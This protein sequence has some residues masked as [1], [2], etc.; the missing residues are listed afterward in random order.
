MTLKEPALANKVNSPSQH[1][2]SAYPT[3]RVG[4]IPMFGTSMWYR[5]EGC[6]KCTEIR[7]EKKSEARK[8]M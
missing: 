8:K 3:H 1:M 7:S 2:F 5:K 4:Y 6:I